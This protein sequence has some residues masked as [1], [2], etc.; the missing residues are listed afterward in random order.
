MRLAS[1]LAFLA[2]LALV[3]F[4]ATNLAFASTAQCQRMVSR[5][6]DALNGVWQYFDLGCP[7]ATCDQQDRCNWAY[8]AA[9]GWC[10][11]A[12]AQSPQA[13][14]VRAHTPGGPGSPTDNADCLPE[15]CPAPLWCEQI[16]VP[17]QDPSFETLTC[18]CL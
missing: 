1:R 9:S 18:P 4:G 6:W 14:L 11:C 17:Q 16:W 8:D 13:C 3:A 12:C 5:Q 7:P 15:S 2:A 10:W